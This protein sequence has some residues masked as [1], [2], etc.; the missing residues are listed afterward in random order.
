MQQ[1]LYNKLNQGWTRS[2]LEQDLTYRVVMAA[3]G[4]IVGYKSVSPTAND[5][6]AQT[7]ADLV[8]PAAT[9]SATQQAIAQFKVVFTENGELQVSPWDTKNKNS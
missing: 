2:D 7:L 3:D 5:Y 9:P 4:D 6:I 8:K 1:Q